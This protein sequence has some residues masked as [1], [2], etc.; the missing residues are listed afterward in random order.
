M[1]QHSKNVTLLEELVNDYVSNAIS[2]AQIYYIHTR[3]DIGK[4]VI[5]PKESHWDTH[6][7]GLANIVGYLYH[8]T[9]LDMALSISPG[10]FLSVSLGQSSFL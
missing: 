5:V 7:C 3:F 9:S 1:G 6:L 4:F 8:K 2:F 10:F